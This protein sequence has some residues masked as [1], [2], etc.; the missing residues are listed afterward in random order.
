MNKFQVE[1]WLT[2]EYY[3]SEKV[4]ERLYICKTTLP[5]VPVVGLTVEFFNFAVEIEHVLWN[6][7]SETFEVMLTATPAVEP[8][9]SEWE[10]QG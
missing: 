3:R 10:Y 9:S 5:F 1:F 2:I 7:E 8:L 4:G 6:I